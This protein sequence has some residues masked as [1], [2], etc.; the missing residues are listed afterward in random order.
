MARNKRKRSSAVDGRSHKK[1][2]DTEHRPPEKGPGRPPKELTLPGKS[3]VLPKRQTA[4]GRATEAF[5]RTL[6]SWVPQLSIKSGECI[7]FQAA[8][9]LLLTMISTALITPLRRVKD[10]ISMSPVFRAVHQVTN[11]SVSKLKHLFENTAMEDMDGEQVLRVPVADRSTETP[12]VRM[13]LR[14]CTPRHLQAISD[15]IDACHSKA[16]AGKVMPTSFPPSTPS[17][18]PPHRPAN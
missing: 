13:D 10:A 8:R 4:V 1:Q 9:V 14:G 16:G 11:V 6:K 7:T 2:D 18:N 17:L 12:S 15:F 3:E 5:K